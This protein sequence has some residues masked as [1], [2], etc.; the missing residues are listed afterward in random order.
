VRTFCQIGLF[1]LIHSFACS[2]YPV[3][4]FIF[5]YRCIIR[6]PEFS[7]F[8]IRRVQKITVFIEKYR[9][10]IFRLNDKFSFWFTYPNLPSCFFGIKSGSSSLMMGKLLLTFIFW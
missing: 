5:F 4:N 8:Y 7:E 6:S 2:V 3:R 9:N 10:M 1:I